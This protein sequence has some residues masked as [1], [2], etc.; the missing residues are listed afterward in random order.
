MS[1]DHRTAG[2]PVVTYHAL[3]EG[4]APLWTPLSRFE[5]ELAA[6]ARAGYRAVPLGEV[7]DRLRYGEAPPERAVAI[8]FDDGYRSV[9]TEAL[10]R[11][12]DR[13][14]TATVFLV[15][16]ACG[17]TSRWPGQ[18]ASVAEARLLDWEEATA[19]TEAG[20]ELGSH[21]VTHAPLTRLSDAAVEEEI[22]GSIGAIG[23]R[24]GAVARLLA[25]PYGAVDDR[26]RAL[27]AAH[28]DGAAGTRPGLVRAASDLL[29]MERIDAHYLSPRR[30]ATLD[31]P[32]TRARLRVRRWM[33]RARRL[34]VQDFERGFRPST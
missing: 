16:G 29:N 2:V 33:R 21:G 15:S 17:G 24:T 31:R 7:V 22:A 4:P 18:P 6:F 12:A 30:I 25:Y 14:W 3:G 23:E 1:R 20:W 5:A 19:L 32:A 11:L 26:V 34:F 13:G 10:P 27:A 9:V 8:T 28:V